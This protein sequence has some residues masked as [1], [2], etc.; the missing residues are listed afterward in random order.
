MAS[1]A[2]FP[3]VLRLVA[4][5]L[6]AAAC[7]LV[8]VGSD[9]QCETTADCVNRGF[10]KTAVCTSDK[11][12]SDPAAGGACVTNADCTA[13]NG[14]KTAI[15]R[16]SDK[17][18]VPLLTIDCFQTFGPVE[19]DD[20]ILLGSVL[21]LKGTNASSGLAELNSAALAREEFQNTV[22]GLPGG[23]GGKPRQLAILGCDDSGDNDT[24]QRAA[25]HLVDL[26]VPAILGP[27]SSG[28]VTA[29][30]NSVTNPK[31]VM[32][33]SPAATS[34][35][36]SGLSIYLW[37]TSPSDV[38]QAIPLEGT[39]NDLEAA[40]KAKYAV[41]KV[42]LALVYKDDSYGQGLYNTITKTLKI[43][44]V[45]VGDPTNAGFFKPVQYPGNAA[46]QA[47]TVAALTAFA[48]N[49]V[50][51]FGTNEAVSQILSPLE[52]A[53]PT[54]GTPP[55]RPFYTLSD[56]GEVQEVLDAC[57]GNDALRTRIRGTVPG[58]R[59]PLF[60]QF[61]L[62]Y[63]GKYGKPADVF[64]M[65]GSYDSVYLLAYAIASLGGKPID[66]TSIAGGMSGLVGGLKTEVGPGGIKT[67]IQTLGSGSKIDIDGA[68][69]P[70]NF[71]LNLHEAVSDIDVWC[72]SKDGSQNPI[73]ISSGQSYDA[74]AGKI[75][76]TF[77][78]P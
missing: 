7:S 21:S 31:K 17:T 35:S 49:V 8:V 37:R 57:K 34:A 71:D 67:A 77:S 12:C 2:W 3:A 10:P 51:F 28:L 25:N 30:A 65:A 66:G 43:N 22:V 48:P 6:G 53:W 72:V 41:A 73:F 74:S 27:D 39:I 23:T 42:K 33:I 36:L 54:G 44:G 40:Y 64:G 38:I 76:G 18:C 55:P 78:C 61:S 32:L 75:G 69:G 11:V 60:Q 13:R 68:S 5:A 24:A 58:T 59:N 62:R 15:C 19:D 46:D 63:Q 52:A 56:G 47:A 26:G 4:L 9:V 1:R 45:P 70:L 20:A 14:G 50:A 29:V 16:K